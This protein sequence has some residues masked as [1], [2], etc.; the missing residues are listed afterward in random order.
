M[1]E[2]TLLVFG[3]RYDCPWRSEM[4]VEEDRF[5]PDPGGLEKA[6]DY[7]ERWAGESHQGTPTEACAVV[8][9]F[10]FV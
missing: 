8:G 7:R 2:Q 6:Q 1:I 10:R 3:D 5:D 4:V 9:Q